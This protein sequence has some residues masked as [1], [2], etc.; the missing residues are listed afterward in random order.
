MAHMIHCRSQFTIIYISM[1]YRARVVC[2]WEMYR[3]AFTLSQRCV[4]TH[5]MTGKR[6]QAS[7]RQHG[8]RRQ[9]LCVHCV[10]RVLE[11][12]VTPTQPYPTLLLNVCRAPCW[13]F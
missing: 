5:R 2:R 1:N 11:P 6:L 8:C 10:A 13:W 3:S 4:A 9:P 12:S 7:T